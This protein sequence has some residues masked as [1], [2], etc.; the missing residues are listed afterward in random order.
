M[1]F[2]FAIE[3]TIATIAKLSQKERMTNF[4]AKVRK[5]GIERAYQTSDEF[6]GKLYQNLMEITSLPEFKSLYDDC[7]S[8][9]SDFLAAQLS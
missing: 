8:H 3:D 2:T 9:R 4:R 6:E 1:H 7:V 5:V